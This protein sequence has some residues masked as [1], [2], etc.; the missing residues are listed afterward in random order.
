MMSPPACCG[1]FSWAARCSASWSRNIPEAATPHSAKALPILS[2]GI[3]G[4][5]T[6]I[7]TASARCQAVAQPVVYLFRR[8]TSELPSSGPRVIPRHIRMVQGAVIVAA[9]GG[10]V[11]S[12]WW[13]RASRTVPPPVS[14]PSPR[15]A[16]VNG[17]LLQQMDSARPPGEADLSGP[18]PTIEQLEKQFSLIVQNQERVNELKTHAASA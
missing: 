14:S 17:S 8:T 11:L 3:I 15:A 18:V 1:P 10:I 5:A 13:T 9:A 12:I 4:Y 16:E 6:R 7:G 2:R